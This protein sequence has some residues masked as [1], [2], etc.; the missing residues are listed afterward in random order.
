MDSEFARQLSDY[1][2]GPEL[3]DILEVPIEELVG[4][5]EE[6][7]LEQENELREYMQYGVR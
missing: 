4:L 1:F 7:I 2:T 3:L 5:L 6:Y